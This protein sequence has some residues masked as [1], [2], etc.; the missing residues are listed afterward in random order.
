M[1]VNSSATG[2]L[3]TPRGLGE[4]FIGRKEQGNDTRE[5]TVTFE[6]QDG[7]GEKVERELEQE[8]LSGET[9][10][11]INRRVRDQHPGQGSINFPG[12]L[13]WMKKSM[14]RNKT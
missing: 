8:N 7:E 14:T 6:D 12:S 9:N 5:K 1:K 10:G 4:Y 2:V 13:R 11:K 3:N